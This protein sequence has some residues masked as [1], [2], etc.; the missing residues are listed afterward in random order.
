MKTTIAIKGTDCASCKAL[1]EDV[2]K[3]IPGIASCAVDYATGATE[4]EHEPTT[5]WRKLKQEIE[6][7]GKY[8]VEI[9]TTAHV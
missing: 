4:V 9:P 1:I 5:D 2:C 8:I 7:I 6:S 3:D